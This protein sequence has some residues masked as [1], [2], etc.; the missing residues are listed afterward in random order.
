MTSG[1]YI[2]AAKTV[3]EKR[4]DQDISQ[5]VDR[6]MEVKPATE[7]MLEMELP[8]VGSDTEDG[9]LVK[10]HTNNRE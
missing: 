6:M 1:A 3:Q 7:R 10:N 4:K 9:E 8:V 2:E 5:H